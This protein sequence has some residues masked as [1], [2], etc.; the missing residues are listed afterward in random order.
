[1]EL[2]REEYE[3]SVK[4]LLANRWGIVKEED[5]FP[6]ERSPYRYATL[7]C[8]LNRPAA[9]ELAAQLVQLSINANAHMTVSQWADGQVYIN[10][11]V[12]RELTPAE[13]CIRTEPPILVRAVPDSAK[14]KL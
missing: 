10:L 12:S 9:I 13:N 1:M 6:L 7:S 2:P 5:Y 14:V 11:S 8:T 3:T 4:Q